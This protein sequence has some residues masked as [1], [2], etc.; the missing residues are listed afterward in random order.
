MNNGD[1]SGRTRLNAAERIVKKH[2]G[3]FCA[4]EWNR[5]AGLTEEKAAALA[6]ELRTSNYQVRSVIRPVKGAAPYEVVFR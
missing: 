4:G 1:V 6:G 5:A 3:Q 2:G